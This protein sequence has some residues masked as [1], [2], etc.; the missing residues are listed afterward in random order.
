MY[1]IKLLYIYAFHIQYTESH[2]KVYPILAYTPQ[3]QT[4]QS[5][6]RKDFE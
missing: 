4:P 1:T 3:T 5:T 2:Q 6:E